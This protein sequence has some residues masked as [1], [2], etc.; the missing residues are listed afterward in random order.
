M[1]RVAISHHIYLENIHGVS[2][3]CY[4]FIESL[5]GAFVI[6]PPITTTS[7][8]ITGVSVIHL[9]LILRSRR[10]T[11]LARLSLEGH[12]TYTYAS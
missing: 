5:G 3:I 4:L 6:F 9:T 11:L 12:D 8:C 2:C 1:S 7:S 10:F